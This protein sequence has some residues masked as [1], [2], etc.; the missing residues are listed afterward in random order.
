MKYQERKVKKKKRVYTR[1]E[2]IHG[3]ARDVTV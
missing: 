1:R 3:D 2:R